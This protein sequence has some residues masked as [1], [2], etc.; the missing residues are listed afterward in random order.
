MKDRWVD[1]DWKLV[2]LLGSDSF[3]QQHKAH[4]EAIHQWCAPEANTG[5]NPA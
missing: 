3:Q 5:A 4:L 2:E 1:S